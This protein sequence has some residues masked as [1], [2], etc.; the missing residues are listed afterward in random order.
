MAESKVVAVGKFKIGIVHGHQV[1]PW[2]EPEALAPILV[3][4]GK[5]EGG[6]G[7]QAVKEEGSGKGK[8]TASLLPLAVLLRSRKDNAKPAVST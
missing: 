8:V 4:E 6:E 2:G 5:G 1:S 3:R 7:G